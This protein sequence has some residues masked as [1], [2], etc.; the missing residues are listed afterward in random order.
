MTVI[1]SETSTKSAPGGLATRGPPTAPAW[2][3]FQMLSIIIPALNERNNIHLSRGPGV[4][5]FLGG[6]SDR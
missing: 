5:P 3:K 2:R 4:N 6:R 1:V